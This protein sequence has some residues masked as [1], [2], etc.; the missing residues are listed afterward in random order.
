MA[1]PA[2]IPDPDD[3]PRRH[4]K[5]TEKLRPD[6]LEALREGF[7]AIKKLRDTNG[8]WFW[9]ELHGAPKQMRALTAKSGYDNLF[10]PWHRAYLTGWSSPCR[11]KSPARDPALVGLACHAR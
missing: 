6:Q 8:F 11:P 9:A 2:P 10:L 5:S 3:A 1:T 4:R 7:A